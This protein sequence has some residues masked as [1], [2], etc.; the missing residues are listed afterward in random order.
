MILSFDPGTENM[1][2]CVLDYQTLELHRVGKLLTTITKQNSYRQRKAYRNQIQ[3]L[4]DTYK[5]QYVVA[6]SYQNRGM[7][8]GAQVELV[9]LMLGILIDKFPGLEL[10]QASTWK[11]H[12]RRQYINDPKVQKQYIKKGKKSYRFEMEHL[13]ESKT[14]SIHEMDAIG[15]GVYKAEKLR[16]ENNLLYKFN[17][18]RLR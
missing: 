2:F 1:A 9:N 11:G 7:F 3:R 18:K 8:R 14:I 12:M 6:E 15:I 17:D 13:L 4:L 10:V 16:N 5:P